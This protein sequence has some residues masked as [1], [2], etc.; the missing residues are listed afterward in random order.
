[1]DHSDHSGPKALLL[2]GGR[3][4]DERH[5]ADHEED[6]VG[7]GAGPLEWTMGLIL[8]MVGL[9]YVAAFLA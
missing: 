9:R 1:L 5:D 2:P 7:R 4:Q 3:G 6:R 8:T